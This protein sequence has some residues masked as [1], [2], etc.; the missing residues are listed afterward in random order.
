MIT[1]LKNQLHRLLPKNSFAS[2]VSALVGG[3]AGS[4]ILLVLAAPLLT[5]LYTPEDFG[6][7]AVYGSLLAIIGVVAS[8]H[9][10]L[11]I[12]L[13]EDDDAAAN[14]AVLSLILVV[15]TSLL[16][17][18]AILLWG[19]M[20]VEFFGVPK[21]ANFL[22]LLP[23]GV[24]LTG[25]YTVFNYCGIRTKRFA[26]IAATKLNQAVATLAIQIVGFK[27]GGV[28]LLLG[29]VAGQSAGT[30]SLAIRTLKRPEFKQVSLSKMKACFLHYKDFPLYTTWSS[31]VNTAGHQLPPL[32]FITLFS[33]GAAGI[34]AVA[35]RLLTMPATLIGGAVAQVFFSHG[36]DGHRSG[37]LNILY[38]KVQNILIQLGLP[39]AILLILFGPELFA[40][41]FGNEW[42]DAGVLSQW[43]VVGAFL[44]FV[45]S[46][47]SSIFSILEMQRL[48]LMLQLFLL[49]ARSVGVFIGV[50]Q[51]SIISAVMYFSIGSAIGYS[52]YLYYGARLSGSTLSVFI[53]S[54]LDGVV[55]AIVVIAPIFI[56]YYSGLQWLTIFL[57]IASLII[58][59]SQCLRIARHHV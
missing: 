40:F 49:L 26:D 14:I 54:I 18:I 50:W 45:V 58:Y 57:S 35:N 6:L 34:Y 56:G 44:G 16:T 5:R 30:T 11:A 8:L 37:N 12:P 48:G 4:Q 21:L 27:L 29:Q 39:P 2:G 36:V 23:A 22:W 52:A 17:C 3:T 38:T 1:Q 15:T 55:K 24:L 43:L 32:I 28:A 46:P 59:A 31:L 7:L 25:F 33:A 10:E 9:Y 47:L 53:K 13:P 42:R 41:S 51:D 19:S 20:V